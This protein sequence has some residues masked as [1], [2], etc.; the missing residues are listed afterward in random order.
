MSG[1]IGS[2][3]NNQ[4]NYQTSETD[5]YGSGNILS[6]LEKRVNSTLEKM[7][8]PLAAG[9]GSQAAVNPQ[10]VVSMMAKLSTE[11]LAGMTHNTLV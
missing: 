6:Q 2:I 10:D 9:A 7:D 11:P 1:N 8:N 4:S 3:S 5:S